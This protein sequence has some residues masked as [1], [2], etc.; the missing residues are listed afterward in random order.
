MKL[1]RVSDSRSPRAPSAPPSPATGSSALPVSRSGCISTNSRRW[2]SPSLRAPRT[3]SARAGAARQPR[4]TLESIA[5]ALVD[6][7]PRAP[8]AHPRLPTGIESA[9]RAR[10]AVTTPAVPPTRRLRSNGT[11]RCMAAGWLCAA[12]CAVIPSCPAATT[13]CRNRDPTIMM[14]NT[15]IMLWLALAAI[16]YLNYEAWMKDYQAI[17]ARGRH[18]GAPGAPRRRRNGARG[19]GSPAAPP[20]VAGTGRRRRRRRPQPSPRPRRRRRPRPA[21]PALHVTT[22][23][24]DIDINL[25]G[26][27]FD[28]ADLLNI[29]CARTRRTCRC[30]CSRTTPPTRCMCCN[31]ARPEPPARPRRR[32][33]RTG[34]RAAPPT[35]SGGRR[36][37]SVPLTWTR[38][39]WP[40]RDEDLRVHPR[41]YSI[42]LVYDVRNDGAA[43]TQA[44]FLFAV[45]AALGTRLRA[46][47]FDVETY[48]F[49]GPAIYDGTKYRKLKV[50]ERR[51]QQLLADA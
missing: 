25:K 8:V 43:G 33:S 12:S 19:D 49:K 28:Q 22:D 36:R 41:L 20:M 16:L 11:V 32:I 51:R 39:S 45:P 9:A 4:Q 37:I 21:A 10:A 35:R 31:R 40:Q 27:E 6:R 47:Y 14:P 34:P 1:I 30:D 3:L 7:A 46:P 2:T 50:D 23:V 44:G 24:L 29:R 18:P 38:R 48:A 42:D 15:R 5:Q 17:A 13:R 26:G